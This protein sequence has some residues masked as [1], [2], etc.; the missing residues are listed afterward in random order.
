MIYFGFDVHERLSHAHKETTI[1]K[2][3]IVVGIL[4]FLLAAYHIY[5]D[6][7]GGGVPLI[8]HLVP[9]AVLAYALYEYRRL[10]HE[11]SSASV[12]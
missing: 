5:A 1:S 8:I 9:I 7:L 10:I 4:F 2:S 6:L 3:M 11:A 12:D